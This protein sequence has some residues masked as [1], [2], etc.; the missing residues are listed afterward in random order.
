MLSEGHTQAHRLPVSVLW[1]LMSRE[2]PGACCR[3]ALFLPRGQSFGQRRD[4][5]WS[6]P[7]S[8][9][10]LPLWLPPLSHFLSRSGWLSKETFLLNVLQSVPGFGLT[11]LALLQADPSL[12]CSTS[13]SGRWRPSALWQTHPGYGAGLGGRG[14][15][16]SC[17]YLNGGGSLCWGD[18]LWFRNSEGAAPGAW[19]EI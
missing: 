8:C 16:C 4:Q 14:P 17:G 18:L 12:D 9:L 2:L 13:A 11:P 15:G 1:L 6:C 19:M 7:C 5:E 3:I 10:S